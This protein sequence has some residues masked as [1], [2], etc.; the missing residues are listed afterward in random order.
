M[1]PLEALEEYRRF[2]LEVATEAGELTLR[3]FRSGLTV[4]LKEDESPVTRADR[5]TESLIRHR[6]RARYPEHTVIGEEEGEERRESRYSWIIDP[7]D[8]TKAF[9]HGVPF[10]TVLIAFAVDE[11]PVVGVVHAPAMGEPVSAAAGAPLQTIGCTGGISGVRRL[12]DAR[13]HSTDFADLMRRYPAGTQKLLSRVK[14]ARTWADGYGYLM[15]ATGRADVMIDPVMSLW[16]IAPL[17]PVLEAAGAGWSD[18]QGRRDM[19]G[20]SIICASSSELRE[21]ALALLSAG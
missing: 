20:S 21:E 17:Y 2:A 6:I 5:E 12:E 13:L 19:P 15:L 4:D 1:A 3:H 8:G 7:I 11:R 16:D 14:A 18:L 9:V 10:Y